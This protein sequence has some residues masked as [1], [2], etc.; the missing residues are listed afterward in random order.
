MAV[1]APL[2]IGPL[3]FYASGPAIKKKKKREKKKIIKD[4]GTRVCVTGYQL[5][6]RNGIL[7]KTAFLTLCGLKEEK[8]KYT[9]TKKKNTP[10]P[11][12]RL[13]PRIFFSFFC[14]N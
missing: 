14:R 10:T 8:N 9:T 2:V 11:K 1:A 4:R 6:P 5:K 12:R 7:A 3:F 13:R